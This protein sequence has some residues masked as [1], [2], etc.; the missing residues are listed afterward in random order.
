MKAA[1]DSLQSVQLHAS[2]AC[3]LIKSCTDFLE[4]KQNDDACNLYIEQSR[5]LAITYNLSLDIVKRKTRVPNRLQGDMIVTDPI[6]RTETCQ[7]VD[8]FLRIDIYKPVIAK[9]LSELNRRFSSE[10]LSILQAVG[11]LVPG[12][13][14]FLNSD[15]LAPMATYY[16]RNQE[17]LNLEIRQMKRMIER[18]TSE[19]TMPV[20]NDNCKLIAFSQFAENYGEAFFEISKLSRIACTIPVTSV[21]SERSFSCLKLIKNHLRTTMLDERLS[22][23]SIL[24]IH[25]VRAQ[26]LDLDKVI[27]KFVAMYPHC[28]IQLHA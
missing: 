15:V 26:A 12:S 17:D 14:T 16:H 21:Q 1:S 3:D 23:I 8:S 27:D 4:E 28:R 22:S 24:S 7:D 20:F 10:N 25:S 2:S 11:A 13:E 5:V 9:A 18:K 19:G 6:G